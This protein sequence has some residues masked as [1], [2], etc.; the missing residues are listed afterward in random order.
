VRVSYRWLSDYVDVTVEPRELG[1]MLTMAG[2]ELEF[3][4]HAGQGLDNVESVRIQ[5]VKDHP[6][7]DALKVCIVNDGGTDHEV[8]CGAP[9]LEPGQVVAWAKPG[10]HLPNGMKIETAE[11]R[12][13]RSEGMLCAADEL[14]LID[15]HSMLYRL[16][17]DA[18]LGANI[19]EVGDLDD[20][21]LDIDI[22]P[23]RPDILCMIG[24]ARE[25]AAHYG[26]KLKRP[27]ARF[28]EPGGE[29]AKIVS[30]DIEDPDR[31][32]RYT[33]LLVKD[34]KIGPSPQWM[35]ARLNAAGVRSINNVVDITNFV[36]LECGQPLHAFDLSLLQGN[37]IVVRRANP[38]ETI[39]TLDEEER[40][41][42]EE[43]LLI[44]DGFGPVAL[45]GVMGGLG[46]GI[47]DLTKDVFIESAYFE[48]T[49]IRR[50]SKRIGLSS[51]SSFRFERGIDYDGVPWGLHRAG[52]LMEALAG[53]SV[54]QGFIDN[55]P[56]DIERRVIELR[57]Q[58]ANEVLGLDLSPQ[59][60]AGLLTSID[61]E[62]EHEQ[63]K[64]KV[65]I[66]SFRVDMAIE[67]DLW[68]EVARLYGYDKIPATIHVGV[69]GDTAGFEMRGNFRFI[70]EIMAGCG[71]TEAVTLTFVSP[72]QLDAVR[73]EPGNYVTLANPLTEE[74]SVMRDTLIP[75]LV[76][77]LGRNHARGVKD[78]ALFEL[79]RVFDEIA[80][81]NLPNEHYSLAV[82]LSGRR[83]GQH[84]SA[85]SGDVDFFDIKGIAEELIT[86]LRIQDAEWIAA[87]DHA[88][89]PGMCAELRIGE[90]RVGV[91][92][93]LTP[94]VLGEFRVT[95]DVFTGE[96][97][98]EALAH[99]SRTFFS[100]QHVSRFPAVERDLAVVVS[101]DVPAADLL[102]IVRSVG[103]ELL[104]CAEIFDLYRGEPLEAGTKSIAVSCLYQSTERTLTEDEVEQV[105]QKVVKEL[106]KRK[107][108]RLRV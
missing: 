25:V 23:N 22:T 34:V 73:Q 93:K 90:K 42:T 69:S 47:S 106:N 51:E 30:V 48:P 85:D 41:L 81:Q 94:E 54:V 67:A 2:F 14:G 7:A 16:P 77:G 13:V 32:P 79:R 26:L 29:V 71:L 39:V 96:F 33:G 44:C 95:G 53:G 40:L 57:P 65:A 59:D 78:V 6:N 24:V 3:L 100:Y 104:H 105:H 49:G 55:A 86:R 11:V 4:E 5:Q 75:S 50:T 61:L 37:R 74:L 88:Y 19:V 91:I 84:W 12:G 82:L 8:V 108:A 1:E 60:M 83:H 97:D 101:D 68:E 80:E 56:K 64:L 63:D 89:M 9:G 76:L 43:D 36:L 15:D 21:V 62:V 52:R 58:R 66:P 102:E 103:G 35:V 28:E 20:W 70:R 45:A 18:P 99:A 17:D 46:S 31:C 10:A 27:E 92:G 98:A 72:Q 38:Q 107:G 87:Q